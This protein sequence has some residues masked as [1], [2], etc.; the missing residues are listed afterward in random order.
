MDLPKPPEDQELKNIIDKLG[1]FVARNGPEFEQMTK[2]KQKDNKKFSFLFGGEFFNYYQ[3]KVTTEQAILKQK[4]KVAEQHAQMQHQGMALRNDP[5]T[6]WQNPMKSEPSIQG[7]PISDPPLLLTQK[8]LQEQILQSEQNLN[9]QHQVLLQQ[10]QVQIEEAV[11]KMQEEKLIVLTSRCDFS[12]ADLD[13]ILQPII[14]SCTKEAISN[15]KSW[16]FVHAQNDKHC[17]AIA[18]YLLRR[19]IS[20]DAEFDLKLHI[21]YLMNDVIHHSVRKNNEDLK[22]ALDSVVI[23]VFCNANIGAD[24]EREKKLSKLLKL[25][26]T[27]EYFCKE[28]IEQLKQPASSLANYQASLITEHASAVQPIMASIQAQYS[29]LQKQHNDFV[30]HV[31]NQLNTS[32]NGMPMQNPNMSDGNGMFPMNGGHQQSNNGMPYSE[33]NQNPSYHHQN[34][35]QHSSNMPFPSNQS[36]QSYNEHPY[37]QP[38]MEG[39]SGQG[40]GQFPP[41]VPDFSRPPPGFPPLGGG[42]PCNVPGP[43]PVPYHELPAALMVPL[44]M[45]FLEQEVMSFILSE[46]NASWEELPSIVYKFHLSHCSRKLVYFE[47]EYRFLQ[48]EDEYV[49]IDSSE[50]NLPPP[51]P[52][53]ERLLN[54]VELF[55]S[56][57]SHERPRNSEGW[58]QLGLYEHFKAKSYARRR[59]QEMLNANLS[60]DY[61]D[62]GGNQN[63]YPYKNDFQSNSNNKKHQKHSRPKSP[64]RRRYRESISPEQKISPPKSRSPSPRPCLRQSRS[65]SPRRRSRSRSSSPIRKRSKSRSTT[66]PSFFGSTYGNPLEEMKI[67]ESNRGHQ[68]LKRMGW[69]GAGLGAAEQ[70]RQTPIDAGDVRDKQDQYKGI[71]ISLNDPF[72]NFRK[73]KG[74][75]FITRMKARAE[76]SGKL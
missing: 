2:N 21:I 66:P 33:H 15:G 35:N 18:A 40:P 38:P 14:E 30:A 74:Q 43:P 42:P 36:M 73:S 9:A 63:N 52:P 39:P 41:V 67:D 57:P 20:S 47:G 13:K 72:E 11:H 31:T 16:I 26:E 58:E 65:P 29:N 49:P 45:P 56:P 23:P 27:N 22:K 8:Q 71:G 60:E 4:M 28:I 17:D 44:I 70:G 64:P 75:A 19:V 68:L 3:Y 1:Q 54:A 51:T 34:F 62:L 61:D 76:E 48:L 55:Y 59:R 5:N 25:W 32:V 6:S 46:C 53:S 24:E 37:N 69:S 10:Q 50:I 12:V 7:P